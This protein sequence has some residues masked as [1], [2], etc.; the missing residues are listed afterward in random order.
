MQQG[1]PGKDKNAILEINW[2]KESNEDES[3]ESHRLRMDEGWEREK[4]GLRKER[5]GAEESR[6]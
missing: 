6:K 3:K 4:K 1:I 2:K 5:E